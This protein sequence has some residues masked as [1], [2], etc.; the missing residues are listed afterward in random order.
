MSFDIKAYKRLKIKHYLK[1]INLFFFFHGACLNTKNWIKVE[2]VL[3]EK[4]LK[5]F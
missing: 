3:N 4:E 2:Q 5:Y 1:K